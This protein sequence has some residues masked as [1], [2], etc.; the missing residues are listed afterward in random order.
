MYRKPKIT[1]ENIVEHEKYYN[2]QP[3]RND[4]SGTLGKGK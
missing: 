3:E 2:E 1:L 4:T